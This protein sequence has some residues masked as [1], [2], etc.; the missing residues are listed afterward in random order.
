LTAKKP[1]R[2]K[3][4]EFPCSRSHD[5]SEWDHFEPREPHAMEDGIEVSKWIIEPK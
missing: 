3:G 1:E 5:R 4:S 2:W